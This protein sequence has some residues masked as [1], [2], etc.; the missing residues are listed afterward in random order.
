MVITSLRIAQQTV[1]A[2]EARAFSIGRQR[3]I[4]RILIFQRGDQVALLVLA[5]VTTTAIWLRVAGLGS[6]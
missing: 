2:V 1:L 4:L 3:T 5:L 6:L